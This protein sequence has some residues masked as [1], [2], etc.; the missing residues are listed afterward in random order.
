MPDEIFDSLYYG[1]TGSI[2]I[3]DFGLSML[4]ALALGVF[5]AFVCT[6]RT[7]SS[8]GFAVTVALLPAASSVVIMMVS[9]NLGA[10]VAVAGAFSLVRYRSA[11]GTAREICAIFVSMA[12]GLAVGMGY[13]GFAALFSVVMGAAMVLGGL[14]CDHAEKGH[15]LEKVL[16]VTVPEDLDYGGVFDDLLSTY[17]TSSRL[18]SVRTSNLGSLSKL[19][20]EVTLR[21][22]SSE[23]A[24]IDAMRCRNGNLEISSSVMPTSVMEL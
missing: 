21:D 4:C 12:T 24:L 18:T 17:T 13:L 3:A 22:A 9:E 10:G 16:R 20:Y 7:R 6:Y 19:T 11:P 15:E 1:E 8:K 2:T 23:R 5:L 14:W